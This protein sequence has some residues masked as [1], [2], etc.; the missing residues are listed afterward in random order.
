MISWMGCVFWQDI[1]PG[2]N[3][4]LC[5]GAAVVSPIYDTL[6]FFILR[7]KVTCPGH[8]GGFVI[9]KTLIG[10]VLLSAEVRARLKRRGKS[11]AKIARIFLK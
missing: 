10:S 11:I 9:Q 6:G 7:M 5:G 1:P 8:C 2:D 3:C 4:P